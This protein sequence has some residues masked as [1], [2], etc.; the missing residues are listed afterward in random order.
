ML[1]GVPLVCALVEVIVCLKEVV[2]CVDVNV[3][4]T[5]ITWLLFPLTVGGKRHSRLFIRHKK[6]LMSIAK[7]VFV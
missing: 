6:N 4:V 5:V 2:V 1:I 3:R 7:M